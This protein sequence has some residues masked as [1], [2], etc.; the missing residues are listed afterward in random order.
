[1]TDTVQPSIKLEVTVDEA[2]Y[3]LMAL[4]QRPLNEVINLFG[5]VKSQAE[6]QVKNLPATPTS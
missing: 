4:S 6:E 2:N 1:M 5:K 3:I